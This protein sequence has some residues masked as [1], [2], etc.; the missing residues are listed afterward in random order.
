MD[1][2]CCESEKRGSLVSCFYSFEEKAE[3]MTKILGKIQFSMKSLR[4]LV[5]RILVESYGILS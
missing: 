2:S 4:W 1:H 5:I 3:P